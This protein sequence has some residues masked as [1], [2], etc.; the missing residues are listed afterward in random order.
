MLIQV[1]TIQRRDAAFLTAIVLSAS[2]VGCRHRSIN[3][4]DMVGSFE[5]HSGDKPQGSICFVLSSN[6]SYSLGDANQ[7]LD[8]MS[9]KGGPPHGTWEL[10]SDATGQKLFIGKSSLPVGREGSSIRVTVNNDLG[11]YCELQLQR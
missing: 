4:E 10:S 8:D 7:P 3:R 6:G 2:L 5:Y 1:M 9:M 11:M